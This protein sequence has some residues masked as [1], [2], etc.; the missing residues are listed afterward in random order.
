VSTAEGLEA[1]PRALAKALGERLQ[2]G[3][4][5][6]SL[7]SRPE[8]FTLALSEGP[9]VRA[10]KLV[11]A[12]APSQI[13]RLC[14]SARDV[15]RVARGYSRCAQTLVSFG[16]ADAE[17]AQRFSHFGFLVPPREDLPFIGCLAPSAIFPGRAPEGSL[18]LTAFA[19]QPWV[20]ASDAELAEALA[21]PLQRLL[22]S[23]TKPELLDVARHGEGIW[24]Y[25]RRHRARTQILRA[26]L[27][28]AGIEIAGAAY[29]GVSVGDAA[30]SGIRAAQAVTPDS[31]AA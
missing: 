6:E 15:A 5:I 7:E 8:G 19:A 31:A 23:S 18:L 29:D 26:R 20:G 30:A 2:L 1:L 21:P 27:R 13:A 25:D 28:A 4:G 24:L 10:R 22:R 11:L 12:L 3:C 16:L 14:S 9:P 17:L